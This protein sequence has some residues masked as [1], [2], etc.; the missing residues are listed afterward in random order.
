MLTSFSAVLPSWVPDYTLWSRH[1][2]FIYPPNS[3]VSWHKWEASGPLRRADNHGYPS[4]SGLDASVLLVKG[5]IVDRVVAVV[6]IEGTTTAALRRIR[7]A[8]LSHNLRSG[9][10]TASPSQGGYTELDDTLCRTL[11]SDRSLTDDACCASEYARY[12]TEVLERSDEEDSRHQEMNPFQTVMIHTVQHWSDCPC[13]RLL[14]F[15]TLN[16][17]LGPP[18]CDVGDILCLIAGYSMP[19]VLRPCQDFFRFVGNVY[20]RGI[21][22]GEALSD[23][24]LS[25]DFVIK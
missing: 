10:G 18:D 22:Y 11:T 21:M 13:R 23:H 24:E 2:G 8:V 7:Q 1:S 9:Q 15:G 20:V 5:A 16:I 6:D 25:S 3:S 19:V 14:L 17:G 4:V 12:Y